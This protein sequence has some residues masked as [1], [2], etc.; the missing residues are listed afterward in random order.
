MNFLPNSDENAKELDNLIDS[1]ESMV[2]IYFVENLA[3]QKG[4]VVTEKMKKN[5]YFRNVEYYFSHK[6]L[7]EQ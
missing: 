6:S 7:R 5:R 3:L 2:R 4:C 1:S